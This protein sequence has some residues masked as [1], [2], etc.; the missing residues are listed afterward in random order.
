[1]CTCVSLTPLLL[2]SPSLF[3]LQN[4]SAIFPGNLFVNTSHVGH[5]LVGGAVVANEI[6]EI[7]F[8]TNSNNK[9]WFSG[10]RDD[11]YGAMAWQYLG[12][13]QEGTYSYFPLSNWSSPNKC[14]GDYDPRERAW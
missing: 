2:T 13:S 9:Q 4:T 7:C 14:P 12:S 3:L 10:L 8:V 6:N 5:K 11:S 1:M